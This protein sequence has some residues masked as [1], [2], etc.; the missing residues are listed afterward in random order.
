[1]KKSLL[2]ISL[3]LILTL[4]PFSSVSAAGTCTLYIKAKITPYTPW[5][6]VYVNGRYKGRLKANKTFNATV[7]RGKRAT[8]MIY[9]NTKRYSYKKTQSV[10]HPTHKIMIHYS[11]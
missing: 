10:N 2:L 6:Y 7:P 8:I 1:M 4:I 5:V 11:T 3:L 9:R